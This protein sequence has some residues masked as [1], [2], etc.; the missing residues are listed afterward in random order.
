MHSL[1]T[2]GWAS[3]AVCLVLVIQTNLCLEMQQECLRLRLP[4]ARWWQ[5]TKDP[6][7]KLIVL[8]AQ[9]PPWAK[10]GYRGRAHASPTKGVVGRSHFFWFT[11]SQISL[12]KNIQYAK[13]VYILN[14]IQAIVNDLNFEDAI[15]WTWTW[16]WRWRKLRN[17]INKTW[18][19]HRPLVWANVKLKIKD[20]RAWDKMLLLKTPHTWV[21]EHG[22][23]K[24]AHI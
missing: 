24:L 23:V 14:P 22:E 2:C 11:T 18:L 8:S 10:S 17:Q 7:R 3:R 15:L 9:N 1:V 6:Q 5:G 16:M 4:C 19:T 21:R 12:Y 13:I 20:F